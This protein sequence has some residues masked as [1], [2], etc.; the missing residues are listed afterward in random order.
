VEVT[1]VPL[2]GAGSVLDVVDEV[3]TGSLVELAV[4]EVDVVPAVVDGSLVEVVLV[5]VVTTVVLPSG[6][7]IVVV[8]VCNALPE[9]SLDSNRVGLVMML[10]LL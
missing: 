2:A 1:V 7:V 5:V 6:L 3:T 10:Q 9:M 4:E 8:L